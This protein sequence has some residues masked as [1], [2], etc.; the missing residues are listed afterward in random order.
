M[1]PVHKAFKLSSP[2]CRYLIGVLATALSLLLWLLL[3]AVLGTDIPLMVFIVGVM[4]A[5]R[6]GGRGPGL[7][8]LV[9]S[10]LA[11]VFVTQGNG[12]LRLIQ[13]PDA[14]R[15]I[16]F[17]IVGLLVTW[18]M[19]ML[20][21]ARL[22]SETTEERFRLLVE[23][24]HDYAL[25][26]TDVQGQII[27]WNPGVERLLGYSE[28]EIIGQPFSCIFTP[29]DIAQGASEQELNDAAR[30]DRASDERWHV[31]KDGTRFFA[32][33]VVHPLRDTYGN[34]RGFAKVLQDITERK[35]LEHVLQGRN[36][37]LT[38]ML[39]AL[40]TQPELGNFLDKVLAT[41]A[42][43]LQSRSV[44]LWLN[45][46]EQNLWS[47]EITFDNGQILRE[48]H[49]GCSTAAD[50]Q[51]SE[52]VPLWQ[53][54]IRTRRPVIVENVAEHPHITN[55]EW[56][57]SR[58]VQALVLVPMLLDKEVL[59]ALTICRADTRRWEP[60][61][62]DLAQALAQQAM[63]ALQM[64]RLEKQGRSAAVLEERNRMAREIH[65]TLA[66]G[67]TGVVLQLTAAEHELAKA[68][69]KAQAHLVR[70]RDLARESLA[71]ARR[72]VWALHPRTLEHSELPDAFTRHVEQMTAGT[73]I[74]SELHVHGRPRSL[75]AEVEHNVLRIGLEALTNALKHARPSLVRIELSFDLGQVRLSVQDNGR[76]FDP[77][78]P[79]ASGGGF[80]LT[81][82]RER[83]ER[84]QGQLTI[85]SQPGQGTEIVLVAPATPVKTEEDTL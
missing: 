79:S 64:T 76:G 16:L 32:T 1:H 29:E 40:M 35:R 74:Q 13:F 21:A 34:L 67:F 61:E 14:I 83:A 52:E 28:A 26:M 27:S 12:T 37:V 60:G 8:T 48:E 41:V 15:L 10:V 2:L 47:L 22:R 73:P 72:S 82:M 55:R 62:I 24:V 69:E 42:D 17:F 18:I 31:R 38:S 71:E 51:L 7:L 20:H 63:L 36:A 56:L 50:S 84:L 53:E 59:G 65:D 30:K 80:G 68:P 23:G 54:M 81:G 44:S 49:I 66:Q 6:Y 39:H 58:G 77:Q 5:T 9:L 45:Q 33:G 3:A 70:A 78:A 46:K 25:F 19:E 4:L 43:L 57:L 75:S 85:S 11:V